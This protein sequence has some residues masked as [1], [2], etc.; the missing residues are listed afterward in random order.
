MKS[1]IRITLTLLMIGGLSLFAASCEHHDRDKIG[2][3]ITDQLQ[4]AITLSRVQSCGDLE[5]TIKDAARDQVELAFQHGGSIYYYP[6]IEVDTNT[7]VPTGGSGQEPSNGGEDKGASDFTGTNVQEQGVDEA[8]IV[9]TDGNILYVLRYGDLV[10]ADGW[11]PE[12]AELLS[13][14]AI[15][16]GGL[17]ML[18]NNGILVVF[19]TVSP[20]NPE[21]AQRLG[22]D[23]ENEV[24]YRGYSLVK[25]TVFDVGDPEAPTVLREQYLEGEYVSSRM[26]GTDVRVVLRTPASMIYDFGY[27]VGGGG[28]SS[29]GG[30]TVEPSD[31]GSVDPNPADGGSTEPGEI[32]VVIPVETDTVVVDDDSGPQPKDPALEEAKTKLLQTIDATSL[33]DWLARRWEVTI[34]GDN[35]SPVVEHQLAECEDHYKQSLSGGIGFLTVVTVDVSQP[36]VHVPAVAVFGQGHLVYASPSRL[37]VANDLYMSGLF[38]MDGAEQDWQVTAIHGFDI[39]AAGEPVA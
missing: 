7:G 37:Y 30:T 20:W 31:G 29:G 23:H 27:A 28:T 10:I 16:G 6:A 26:V 35:T 25:V 4:G 18:Y 13:T 24:V 2:E 39:T 32:D 38:L 11:P 34:P 14:T 22:I 3:S 5:A 1:I 36:T 8:D 17:E 21:V 33:A 19:S 12:D 9:K 15:E